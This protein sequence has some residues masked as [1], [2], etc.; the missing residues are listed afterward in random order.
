MLYTILTLFV[1]SFALYLISFAMKNKYKE[2]EDQ[3]E[4]IS[5]STMQ[6]NYQ[7]KK[8]M[9]VLEEELLIDD[10]SNSSYSTKKQESVLKSSQP[11][12]SQ[13]PLVQRVLHMYEQGYTTKDIAQETSLHEHDILTTL[14]QYSTKG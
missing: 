2:L 7:L 1:V 9:K 13:P 10:Y 4:Q 6:E 5:I 11:G 8:K 3:V 14:R 12:S